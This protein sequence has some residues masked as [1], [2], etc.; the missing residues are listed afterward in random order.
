MH[1]DAWVGAINLSEDKVKLLR[2]MFKCVQCRSN[3][4][5]LPNCPLMKN[6]IIKKKPRDTN[7][8]ELESQARPIGGVSSVAT[9]MSSPSVVSPVMPES[10]P[11]SLSPVLEE[12]EESYA[13]DHIASVEFDLL[14]NFGSLDLTT[15]EIGLL[16][17]APALISPLGSVCSASSSQLNSAQE[18]SPHH[19]KLIVDSGCTRHMV[20][21]RSAFISYKDTPNSYVILADKS[22]VPCLGTGVVYFTLQNKSVLLHEVLHVPKL[23]SPLLS[24]RCFR[25][26]HG[27]SFVADNSGSF[28]TFPDFI[29]PVDDSSDCT[30]DGC[31][32]VQRSLDFDSHLVGCSA[33]VSDNTRF[34][35]SRRPV[36]LSSP[37]QA[38]TLATPVMSS[39]HPTLADTPN[40]P[41]VPEEKLTSLPSEQLNSILDDLNIPSSTTLDDKLS[42]TQ[43]QEVTNAIVAHLQKYGRVTTELLH[44]VRDG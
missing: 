39:P 30:I 42:P 3:E 8:P 29:L 25:R 41:S 24:V 34:R 37:P 13:D 1:K 9:P 31:L 36:R 6:W 2:S 20:P 7:T 43:L 10:L 44:F 12:P 17:S 28:L 27:C 22:R 18:S 5:T 19:F 11:R 33:A 16:Y 23:R 14:E 38:S 15:S 35:M 26:L 21:F 32:G 40:L 4:H